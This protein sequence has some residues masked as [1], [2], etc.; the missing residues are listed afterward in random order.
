M[1]VNLINRV[2]EFDALRS[3][4]DGVFAS[5]PN[6]S[7]FVSW[8]WLRG[9]FET[10]PHPWTVLA[11]RREAGGPW[12]GFMPISVRGGAIYR[13]D[14]V[15]EIRMAGEPA[16]DYTGFVCEP[17]VE[18]EVIG[19]FADF[20]ANHMQWDRLRLKEVNDSRI[21]MFVQALPARSVQ[22]HEGTGTCCPYIPLPTTWEEYLQTG[23]TY[24][25]RK[26]LRK[27]LRLVERECR[28]TH[29]NGTNSEDQI[30]ALLKLAA[31]KDH[32]VAENSVPRF[33]AIFRSCA[34]AGIASITIV[35]KAD[36]PIAG[37]GSFVDRKAGSLDFYLTG[38]DDQ[39]AEYSP[40]RVVNALCIQH[41]ID[42]K[43]KVLDFLRGDEPY[44]FQFG[45]QRRFT[46]NVTMLRRS[47]HTATRLAVSRARK[48][49][50]I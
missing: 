39:F 37:M 42:Q 34:D 30:E 25:T 15:R 16:A 17:S 47:L 5:D 3:S 48:K 44:K 9:W 6:A 36:A 50:G 13:F 27:K 1:Q 29:L 40:G 28:V 49:L 46:R 22:V 38:Y 20:I 19:G 2:D 23:L 35:W 31:M 43:L 26:S 32:H 10:S 21:D 4:W 33:R 45:A 11:A 7:V 12:M 24:E 41:A 18:R 8:A 14:Q